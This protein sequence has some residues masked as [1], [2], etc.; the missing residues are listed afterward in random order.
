MTNPGIEFDDAHLAKRFIFCKPAVDEWAKLI[1]RKALYLRSCPDQLSLI[2]KIIECIDLTTLSGDDTPSRV[3][4]LF[5]LAVNPL[6]SNPCVQCAAVCVYPS[7][8]LDVSNIRAYIQKEG[9]YSPKIASVATG[10]PSGQTDIESRLM[11]IKYAV[12]AGADEIDI[13]INREKALK[14]D[15]IGVYNEIKR[16]KAACILNDHGH[17]H[18]KSILAVGELGSLGNVYAAS[19]VS[20]MAGADFIKTSTGKES[21]FNADITSGLVMAVAIRDFERITKGIKIGIKPAG[22]V[23]TY[24]QALE[25]IVLVWSELGFD[26]VDRNLFRIG[27]SGLLNDLIQKYEQII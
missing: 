21:Q 27:A 23:K 12:Q 13:V 1:K 26:R 6:N 25:W 20:M 3:Q 7:R 9:K 5:K 2:V 15:W 4:R 11:E 24:L 14:G 22:G 17:V 10:F 16:M 18:M 19:M 8:V